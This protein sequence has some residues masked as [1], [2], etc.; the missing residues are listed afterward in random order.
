MASQISQKCLNLWQSLTSK[1]S[2]LSAF[3]VFNLRNVSIR[4]FCQEDFEFLWLKN[5]ISDGNYPMRILNWS[6]NFSDKDSPILPIWLSLKHVP[7]ILY[8]PEALFELVRPFGPPIR[9]DST[10]ADFTRLE[11]TRILVEFDVY[12]PVQRLFGLVFKGKKSKIL[13]SLILY[14]AIALTVLNLVILLI[15]VLLNTHT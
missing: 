14:L 7:I 13:S 1:V 6:P 11:R 3:S 15:C 5:A 10:M 8:Y 9:V 2:T 12:K 4:C